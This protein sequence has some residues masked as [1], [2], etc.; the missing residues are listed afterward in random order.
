MFITALFT[1]AKTQKQP[2]YTWTDEWIKKMECTY[3][4]EYYS[5]IKKKW[6]TAIC[7]H[8]DGPRDYHTKSSMPDKERQISH[9]IT[10]VWNLKCVCV[11]V[12]IYCQ[13][14]T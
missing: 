5:A 12:Y 2:K 9:A 6:K 13:I 14:Q 10:Y 8:T 7:S 11:C 3:T 1:I 4:L